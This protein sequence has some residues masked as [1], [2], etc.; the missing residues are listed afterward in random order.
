MIEPSHSQPSFLYIV[1][2]TFEPGTADVAQ[3]WL[4]WLREIHLSEVL[5]A[6]AISADVIQISND[7]ERYEIHYRFASEVDFS[8]Y[9]RDQAPS[10]RAD[11]LSR[12]PLSLGLAYER[13]AGTIL[14]S[15]R[16]E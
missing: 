6:G 1:R 14:F 5:A 8:R 13:R 15:R 2:C 3:R 10:L 12:F 9:E 11:G 4:N 7:L 16:I